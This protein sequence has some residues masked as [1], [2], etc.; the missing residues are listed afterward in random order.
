MFFLFFQAKT[1]IDIPI[2][3]ESEHSPNYASPQTTP[4]HLTKTLSDN[5]IQKRSLISSVT[6]SIQQIMQHFSPASNQIELNA[7][8]DAELNPAIAKLTLGTLCP[9]LY[10]VLS[11]G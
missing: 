4:I 10:A 1:V 7:L 3:E 8:G 11:D 6:E 2:T 9:A 5:L